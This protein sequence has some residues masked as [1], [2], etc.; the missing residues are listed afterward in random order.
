MKKYK[1]KFDNLVKDYDSYRPRYPDIFF[2]EIWHWSNQQKPIQHIIDIGAGTGILLEGL[3]PP[4]SQKHQFFAIDISETM[5]S[6]GAKKFPFINWI[7]GQAEN[8]LSNFTQID[9]AL[10]G[11]SLQWL[12]RKNILHQ[13]KE[14]LNNL[15]MVCILQ[16]N[17]DYNKNKFLYQYE[18]LLEHFHPKYTRTYRQHNYRQELQEIFHTPH[19][20]FIYLET[21]WEQVVSK[22]EFIGMSNSSTQ[23]QTIKLLK[24]AKFQ[25]KLHNL[26]SQ[27]LHNEKLLINYQSELFIIKKKYN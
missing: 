24:G 6:Y 10:F 4:F 15:G 13:I 7:H 18:N 26:I 12:Q 9:I 16:N 1:E 8:I 5:V 17:R 21:I 23:I 20:I 22:H 19:Y 3:I 2:Q 11:Q 14:R 25:E 27:Y